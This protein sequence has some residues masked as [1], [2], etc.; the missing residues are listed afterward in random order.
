MAQITKTRVGLDVSTGAFA[1]QISGLVAGEDIAI[2]DACYIADDGLVYLSDGSVMGPAN[3]VFGFAP[4][5]VDSGE[6]IT[7]FGFGSRFAYGA[8]LTPG[9]MLY[10]S[11]TTPGG[12]A[13]REVALAPVVVAVILSET[14]ILAI[15]VGYEAPS[16]SSV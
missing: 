2:G 9:Q 16:V 8:S 1:V 15:C 5:A 4:R 11:E 12:L 6:P 7:L 13:D 10:L 3:A 14:D